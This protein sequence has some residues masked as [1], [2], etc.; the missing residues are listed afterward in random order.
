[1]AFTRASFPQSLHFS[2]QHLEQ[3]KHRL[4][5]QLEVMEEEYEQRV[6]DLKVD[7]AKLRAQLLE[8]ETTARASEKERAS[9]ASGLAEQ[10]Q[11]LASEV[12]EG[13]KREAELQAKLD[14]L[15]AQFDTK[16]VSMRDHVL[17]L[18]TMREEVRFILPHFLPKMSLEKGNEIP[19]Y[20]SDQHRKRA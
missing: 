20:I 19:V 4:R 18:D 10:N 15:R 5:L 1:M 2:L 3:E 17:H 11:R 9:L 12:E 7:L 14:E 13:A 16:R 8:V 6:A